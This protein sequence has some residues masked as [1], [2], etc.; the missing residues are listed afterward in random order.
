MDPA[1]RSDRRVV[2]CRT[3]LFDIGH[4]QRPLTRLGHRRLRQEL[5]VHE[6]RVPPRYGTERASIVAKFERI[7]RSLG[8][9]RMPKSGDFGDL[10]MTQS[11]TLRPTRPLP[12]SVEL[13]ADAR[14]R[15]S[16]PSGP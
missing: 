7:W 16:G 14:K 6:P 10:L 15:D 9:W 11:L 2:I 12:P 4:K 8:T 3:E 5:N 1:Q 13:R